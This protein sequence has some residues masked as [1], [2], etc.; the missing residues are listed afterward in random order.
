MV[1]EEKNVIKSGLYSEVAKDGYE[2]ELEDY[3]ITYDY[4]ER[5][6]YEVIDVIKK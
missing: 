1:A 6:K 3:I 4:Y 2:L 5:T